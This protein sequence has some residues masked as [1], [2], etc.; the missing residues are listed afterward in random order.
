[1]P[2]QTVGQSVYVK[3]TFR[4]LLKSVAL[5]PEVRLILTNRK[6]MLG[7]AILLFFI[8]VAIFPE[9]ISGTARPEQFVARAHLEPMTEYRGH[10]F[11]LGTTRQGQDMFAQLVWGTRTTLFVGFAAGSIILAIAIVVGLSA[12]YWGGAIDELLS[13]IMNIFLVMPGLP[14]IIVMATVLEQ[15][16]PYTVIFVLGFV[17]WAYGARVLRAQTLA[18]RNSEFVT[19][20]RVAGEPGWRIIF[21]EI[22]PNM[23]PLAISAWIG[24]VLFAILAETGL[25]FVGV[26]D[27]A[28]ISWGT[29]LY[30]AQQNQALLVGAWWTFFPP[31]ICI[32]LIAVALTLI[33]NAIDEIS[34]PRL[35]G[36]SQ[37]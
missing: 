32:G 1:M 21:F 26:G 2:S 11:I 23:I 5:P 33:N 12:G 25:N 17:N 35:R 15:P 37:T 13:A 18:L 19:A 3:N 36:G 34:D 20:A 29:I 4:W 16:G 24:A 28:S 30:W 27:A 7:V 6:A 9:Q 10:T 8:I 14:L 22:L 31:G